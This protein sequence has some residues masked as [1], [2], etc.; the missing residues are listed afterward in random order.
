MRSPF[1]LCAHLS[2]DSMK[3]HLSFSLAAVTN[4]LFNYE[5]EILYEDRL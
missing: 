2:Q 5:Y 4:E 3:F 1:C